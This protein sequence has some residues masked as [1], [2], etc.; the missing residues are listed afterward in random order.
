[1]RTGEEMYD[2]C[3][4][5]GYGSGMTRGWGIKHFNL[6]AAALGPDEEVKMCFIGLHNYRS[7]TQHDSNF[8][9]VVTNKR[10]IMSQKKLIGETFQT[11]S[12][13]NIN[14]ITFESGLAFGIMTIDTIREKFNICLDKVSAKKINEEIH[15]VLDSLK[16]ISTDT[17]GNISAADEIKKYKELLDLGAITQEEFDHKK[18]ELLNL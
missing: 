10:I 17:N 13:G 9:Y 14:D 15:T 2:Y 4:K 11:V 5:N 12:L 18:K 7:M 3:I 1:M 16:R 6:A 8:A